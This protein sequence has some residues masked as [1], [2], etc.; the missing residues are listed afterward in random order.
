[1]VSSLFACSFMGTECPAP[2]ESLWKSQ[3]AHHC[4][5]AYLYQPSDARQAI[6]RD[7]L[8]TLCAMFADPTFRARVEA[9]EL[10]LERPTSCTAERAPIVITGKGLVTSLLDRTFAPIHYLANINVGANANTM[11]CPNR[12]S[13]DPP[14]IDQ[15]RSEDP[16]VRAD[17]LNTLAHELT[18]LVPTDPNCDC[19]N[20][21]PCEMAF[22]DKDHDACT[23]G[24]LVSYHFG[25][26]VECHYLHPTKNEE[27]AF[28][29]CLKGRRS[30]TNDCVREISDIVKSCESAR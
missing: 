28:S 17:Y 19:T 8:D 23:D 5:S 3:G 11:M 22:V 20:A 12:T 16:K 10:W 25:D 14:R 9:E 21:H 4:F 2:S 1:M 15:W 30:S 18:H 7:S 26:L 27:A 24:R 29:S 13:I 6:L